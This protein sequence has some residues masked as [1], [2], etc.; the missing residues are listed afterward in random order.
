MKVK[1]A[2]CGYLATQG[3]YYGNYCGMGQD[4]NFP[5]PTDAL[6]AACSAHDFCYSQR[7]RF[8]C[9]CDRT[10]AMHAGEIA[11]SPE[12][13]PYVAEHAGL[14]RELFSQNPCVR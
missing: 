11:D 13:D 2:A 8:D 7:G 4:D 1:A 12:S 6:D 9:A 3:V 5:P 10:L 14:V